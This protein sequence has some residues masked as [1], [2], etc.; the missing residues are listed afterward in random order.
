MAMSMPIFGDWGRDIEA[1]KRT[2][3]GW[4]LACWKSISTQGMNDSDD[5][6]QDMNMI[7]AH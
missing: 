7:V 5:D 2:L 6:G 3:F 1:V 4:R